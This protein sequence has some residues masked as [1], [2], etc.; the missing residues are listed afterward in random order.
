MELP[1]PSNHPKMTVKI[2]PS[3]CLGPGDPGA[4]SLGFA[5]G[6]RAQGVEKAMLAI[7]AVVVFRYR[8]Q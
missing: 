2:K 4:V 5:D 1:L 6:G 8:P 3:C 7:P